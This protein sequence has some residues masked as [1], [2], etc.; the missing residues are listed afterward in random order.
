MLLSTLVY[1]PH[2][3]VAATSNTFAGNDRLRKATNQLDLSASF[4]VSD[5]LRLTF[6]GFNLLN[7]KLIEYQGVEAR[8]RSLDLDGR[9]FTLGAQYVF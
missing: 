5:N 9:T 1:N 3:F 4:E 2:Y 8:F 7:K 6:E